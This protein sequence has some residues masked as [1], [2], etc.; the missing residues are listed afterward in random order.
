M[1]LKQY[2]CFG[3]LFTIS[4][5]GSS[6]VLE[7]AD[8]S[9]KTL[10]ITSTFVARGGQ[11]FNAKANFGELKCTIIIQNENGGYANQT[12]LVVVLPVDITIVSNPHNP[13]MYR[14]G[15]DY[16]TGWPGSLVFDLHNMSVGQDKT[17]EFIFTMSPFGNKIGAYVF[18]GCP[19]PNPG[20]NFKET[21][22]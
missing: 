17:I 8:V 21:S 1:R 7:K 13:I 19:D 11:V 20:N 5:L 2:Y 9:I 10:T 3:S 18:S 22:Y 14:S 6:Q 4:L 16:R 15:S 12:K